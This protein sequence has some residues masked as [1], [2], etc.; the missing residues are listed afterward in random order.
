MTDLSQRALH[1]TQVVIIVHIVQAA[2]DDVE[3]LK[4][5][6]LHFFKIKVQC[7]HLRVGGVATA[8]DHLGASYLHTQHRKKNDGVTSCLTCVTRHPD[9]RTEGGKSLHPKQF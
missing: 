2:A 4:A 9:K 7:E 8:M 5:Q 6:T 3:Q 1:R